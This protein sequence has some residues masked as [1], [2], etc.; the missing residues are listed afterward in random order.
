V[1]SSQDPRRLAGV[2]PDDPIPRAND[3]GETYQALYRRYRPQRFGDVRGQEHVTRALRNAVREER[4]AH[5]YLFSGPRGTG[6]TS[7]ARILAMALNCDA[8][9]DGEPDGTC[10]SCMA[11][12]SGSSMDVFELDAASNRKLDEMRDL[13]SRVALGTPGRWKVYIVDEVHQLTPDAASALLKTLEEPPSHVVFVLATTDPQKVL[14]TIQSRT[15]HFEFHLLDGDVLAGLLGDINRDADLGLPTDIVRLAVQKGRGSAR[16]AESALEQLAA[17]GG[18]AEDA[19]P[20]VALATALAERDVGGVLQAVARAV[21]NGRDPRRLGSDLVE[22]LREA[23]LANQA[24]SLVLLPAAETALLAEEAGR[25]GLPLLVRSMEAIGQALV[26]MRDSVDPRVTLEVALVR[27]ASPA[28]DASPAGL[29][30]RVERLERAFAEASGPAVAQRPAAPMGAASSPHT[31]APPY[32]SAGTPLSEAPPYDEGP[33]AS[34]PSPPPPS[35]PS[36]SP[37]PVT[38]SPAPANPAEARAALGAY[39]R[40][41]PKAATPPAPQP[42]QNVGEQAPPGGGRSLGPAQMGVPA[43]ER[44]MPRSPEVA[45]TTGGSGASSHAPAPRS[46]PALPTRDELTKAWGDT[47]LGSLGRPAQAYL[48]QGHFTEVG[49]AAVFALPDLS[50][51]TRASKFAAEAEA[52]LAKY[53]GRPVPLRIVLDEQAAPPSHEPAGPVPEEDAYDL[54]ELTEAPAVAEVSAEQRILDIFPG[55]VVES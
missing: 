5:A 9:V 16:D 48:G 23:F 53:F 41:T 1:A 22:H 40:G 55:A 14:P 34:S 42:S 26:D 54:D 38:P 19:A 31:A 15:Q 37:P 3:A 46:G 8:P 2:T 27:L 35:A 36:S 32:E 13:L 25:L 11:V 52:A 47:V 21:A 30:E 29:L 4:V 7:T 12:R 6:K 18:E 44:D 24:P 51:V 50:W 20:I 49:D 45:G 39:L 43:P 33:R 10:R 17:A 28:V